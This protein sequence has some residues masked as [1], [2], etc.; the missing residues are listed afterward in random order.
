MH[1][2]PLSALFNAAGYAY[3]YQVFVSEFVRLCVSVC[4]RLLSLVQTLFRQPRQ[5]Q[6]VMV[7][8]EWQVSNMSLLSF[9]VLLPLKLRVVQSGSGYAA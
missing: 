9:L 7:L 1:L 3:T 2:I 6:I 8:R 4:A 5:S